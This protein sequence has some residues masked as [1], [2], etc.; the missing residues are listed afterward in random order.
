MAQAD[1]GSQLQTAADD[2]AA[3]VGLLNGEVAFNKTLASTLERINELRSTL[4]SVQG[5]ILDYRL[6]DAVALFQVAERQ[7]GSIQVGRNTRP[8]ELLGAKIADSRIALEKALT[9]CWDSIIHIDATNSMISIQNE[10]DRKSGS[11]HTGISSSD[12]GT[13][14]TGIDTIVSALTQLDLLKSKIITLQKG[15]DNV[16]ITPRL[17]SQADGTV[18]S[19]VTERD[20]IWATERS[21]DLSTAKL[22]SDIHMLVDYLSIHLPPA[23]AIP[24]SEILMPSLIS[25]LESGP[26]LSS[27][28]ADL[29]GIADFQNTLDLVLNFANTLDKHGWQGKS[30]LEEWTNQAP[31][32][33]LGKRRETS[34]QKIREALMKGL[35]EPRAVERIETQTVSRGDG[36]FTASGSNDDWDAHWSDEDKEENLNLGFSNHEDTPAE[37]VE[38]DVSAWG[39]EDDTAEESNEQRNGQTGNTTDETDTWGWGDED[40]AGGSSKAPALLPRQAHP[41]NTNGRA[42]SKPSAERQITL[43]ETYNITALPEQILEVIV[44]VILDFERLSQPGSVSMSFLIDIN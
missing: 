27:V 30:S 29:E 15:I 1:E 23:I 42:G 6:L 39:L 11:F 16:I 31:R 14:S 7:L 22:L 36:M 41:P 21:P 32:V 38:E 33:W 19:L 28:P 12:L 20:A 34:L 5:A 25:R 35:G 10:A 4:D 13:T 9:E 17:R 2:A 37:V 8:A 24:L 40:N 3:K 18:A 44:Q 43:R 26:L